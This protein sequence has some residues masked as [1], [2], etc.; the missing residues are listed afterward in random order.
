MVETQKTLKR[1]RRDEKDTWK[2]CTK[3]DLNEPDYYDGVVSD[4]EP[5][6]PEWEVKW[7]LRTT[8]VN[9]ASEC[10]EIP[11]VIQIPKG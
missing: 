4:P 1:S 5:D 3:K 10:N 7:A 9:K 8:A 6:I 2:N 11:T